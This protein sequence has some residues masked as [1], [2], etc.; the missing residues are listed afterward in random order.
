MDDSENLDLPE[1]TQDYED[2]VSVSHEYLTKQQQI[3]SDKYA[4]GSYE[5]YFVD[6]EK[7][8]ITFSDKWVEKIKIIFESVWTFSEISQTWLWAWVIHIF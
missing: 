5:S 8:V 2:I 4:I 7:W 3:I 1:I 6:G